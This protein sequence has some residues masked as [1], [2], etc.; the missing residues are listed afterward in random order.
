MDHL[1]RFMRF[2]APY[3]SVVSTH[4][5][6]DLDT[7]PTLSRGFTIFTQTG[8]AVC[9][10]PSWVTGGDTRELAGRRVWAFSDF[11]LHDVGTGDGLA[12][13]SASGTQLRTAPLV[14]V[15]E[16]FGYLH[17]GSAPTVDDAITRHGAQA[18][19]SSARYAALS[20]D[21]RAELLAFIK[22]L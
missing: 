1:A 2:L 4:T 12:L 16:A 5:N 14:G 20:A 17:D 13:G 19:E 15:Q 10:K 7:D 18:R 8:C 11:L 3:P 6:D 9:H 22:G 21:D